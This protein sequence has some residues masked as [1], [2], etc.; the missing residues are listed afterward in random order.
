MHI[1][2]KNKKK[3][4][5][6]K[7]RKHK[8]DKL[9]PKITKINDYSVLFLPL[10]N[11]KIFYA[12]A[13]IY[14][15][16]IIEN[17][18][19]SGISHLLEHVIMDS[20][21]KC[22]K[23]SCFHY[24]EK[25]GTYSNAHTG[26]T[27]IKFWRQGLSKYAN[28]IMDYIATIVVNPFIYQKSITK[29]KA[30]VRNELTT[31]FNNPVWKLNNF[32][33]K[34]LYTK[35][36]LIYTNDWPQQIKN[37]K[38]IKKNDLIQFAKKYFHQ[39]R[40]LFVVAGD[41]NKIQ[42]TNI[43]KRKLKKKQNIRCIS[44]NPSCYTLQKKVLFV[45]HK[46]AKNTKIRIYFPSI[47]KTFNKDSHYYPFISQL[48]GSSGNG[49]LFDELRTKLNLV[50]GAKCNLLNNSCGHFFF[51]TI[52]TLD[53]NVLKVLFKFFEIIEK[54]KKNTISDKKLSHF[55]NRYLF[56]NF[57]VKWNSSGIASFFEDTI[58][59]Q[60]RKSDKNILSYNQILKKIKHL[61]KDKIR[62]LIR[63]IFNTEQCMVGYIGK[64]KV[65]FTIKD[66]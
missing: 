3:S 63:S 58:F 1:T 52:S 66:F 65:N 17:K 43:L 39:D 55:K 30:A 51:I 41:Y 28:D 45:K 35:D 5:K 22:N 21:K 33:D 50:Y 62:N 47:T 40:I 38:N 4:S 46:D 2:S 53:K 20:W 64:K 9:I 26:N 48:I 57:N 11:C 42:I 36:G 24:W 54:Y 49:I 25:Y 18:N 8:L 15:G 12:S 6:N 60:L 59:Y 14:G 13:I 27:E 7:T 10:P 37:L 29:E 23:K 16:N 61:S 31:Y 19:N 56:N 34:H 32:M 44:F